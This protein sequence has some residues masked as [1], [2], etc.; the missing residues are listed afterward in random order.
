[1]KRHRSVVANMLD[2]NIVENQVRIP[3]ALMRSLSGLYPRE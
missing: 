1:M 3:V 2:Y